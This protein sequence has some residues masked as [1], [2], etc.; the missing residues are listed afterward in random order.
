MALSMADRVGL[1]D[2][3]RL[4]FLGSPDELVADGELMNRYLGVHAAAVD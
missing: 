3:G 4:A 2:G 1:I